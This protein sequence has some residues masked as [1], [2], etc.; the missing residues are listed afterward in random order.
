MDPLSP[1]P[2]PDTPVPGTPLAP[3]PVPPPMLE[4]FLRPLFDLN[5]KPGCSNPI[6]PR[7][8]C[9][10]VRAL[11][12]TKTELLKCHTCQQTY[13][14]GKECQR[15]TF[16]SG[17]KENCEVLASLQTA[18]MLL[19][20]LMSHKD[21]FE[22]RNRAEMTIVM[23][24]SAC[25]LPVKDDVK[26]ESKERKTRCLEDVLIKIQREGVQE[27]VGKGVLKALLTH[28][29][30]YG[31]VLLN[32]L[33]IAMYPAKDT[34]AQL[35]S[36][37]YAGFQ[38]N[39]QQQQQQQPFTSVHL[40]VD[41][42][43]FELTNLSPAAIY[44]RDVRNKSGSAFFLIIMK[45]E[46]GRYERGINVWTS[47]LGGFV[48]QAWQD[49]FHLFHCLTPNASV[50]GLDLSNPYAHDMEPKLLE[51]FFGRLNEL[52]DSYRSPAQRRKT[53]REIF[54]LDDSIQLDED[55]PV[56]RLVT[57]HMLLALN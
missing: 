55:F 37:V 45:T 23:G 34:S 7:D 3:V 27:P 35:V 46:D 17:H 21:N 24:Q 20:S 38:A 18:R 47:P 32:L 25:L 44:S 36:V 39:G 11:V 10:P 33:A 9:Y 41:G 15:A 19:V 26:E 30:S 29:I 1:N 50:K 22:I 40:A 42:L 2:V 51:R 56:F 52:A 12:E 4:C 57:T 54:A 43:R 13:Y 53:F 16:K 28:D 31:L 8:Q 6:C 5:Y 48:V 49:R 14:C